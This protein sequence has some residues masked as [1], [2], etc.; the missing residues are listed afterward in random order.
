MVGV[1]V[2]DMIVMLEVGA[3]KVE[4]GCSVGVVEECVM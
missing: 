4:L 2:S 3:E 1:M